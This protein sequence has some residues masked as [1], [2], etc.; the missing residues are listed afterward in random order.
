MVPTAWPAGVEGAGP[1]ATATIAGAGAGVTE[2]SVERGVGA[3]KEGSG[4][5]CAGLGLSE[6]LSSEFGLSEGIDALDCTFPVS[7][8]AEG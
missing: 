3:S 4:G 2:G 1:E 8:L 7:G 6:E 5:L